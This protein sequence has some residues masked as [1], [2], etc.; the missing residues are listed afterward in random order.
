MGIRVSSDCPI[1]KLAATPCHGILVPSDFG[2]TRATSRDLPML[3]VIF[4]SGL[5]LTYGVAA[6]LPNGKLKTRKSQTIL[7][8]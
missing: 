2:R 6:N 3:L 7:Y 8:L 1:G 4:T 5:I